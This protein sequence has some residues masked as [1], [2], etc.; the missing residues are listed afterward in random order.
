[1]EWR[2]GRDDGRGFPECARL[3]IPSSSKPPQAE[4]VTEFGGIRETKWQ[5]AFES[6]RW[7]AFKAF[8]DPTVFIEKLSRA[9]V[10]SKSKSSLTISEHLGCR[11][12]RLYHPAPPSEDS[13]RSS[14]S[15][16]SAAQDLV[17]SKAAVRLSELAGY[18]NAGTV[19]FLYQPETPVLRS[20]R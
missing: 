13:G 1:M 15:R 7:E 19:E 16:A 12:A 6:A 8:G 5:D 20:W 10:M 9:P 2:S 14:F 3:G 4:A 17:L 11:R 18:R